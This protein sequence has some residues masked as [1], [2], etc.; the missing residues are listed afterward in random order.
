MST[1]VES[2]AA[3]AA[4]DNVEPVEAKEE[5]TPISLLHFRRRLFRTRLNRFTRTHKSLSEDLEKLFAAE[6][7]DESK[8]AIV[9]K[10]NQVI[11]NFVF[12]Y[13]F[14]D[15]PDSDGRNQIPEDF[16]A[17]LK[18]VLTDKHFSAF[19]KA[20]TASKEEYEKELPAEVAKEVVDKLLKFVSVKEPDH[21]VKRF[22]AILDDLTEQ[23][24]ARKGEPREPRQRKRRDSKAS[25]SS[26]DS[27]GKKP[28][29][30]KKEEGLEDKLRQ[31]L[32]DVAKRS[33]SVRFSKDDFASFSEA[34]S[35]LDALFNETV[36]EILS[37][38]QSLRSRFD[39]I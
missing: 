15:K 29:K 16:K 25:V 39:K 31:V 24:E 11:R 35:Q 4:V 30:G 10:T 8:A 18:Q 26:K 14:P 17:E 9:K 1:Q 34:Q 36:T 33:Q 21:I 23:L 5:K 32:K 28:K 19:E 27:K 12:T 13:N 22:E 38:K 2:Q 20:L 3:A 37:M 6:S 7:T